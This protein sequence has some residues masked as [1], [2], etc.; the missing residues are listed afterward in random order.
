MNNKLNKHD[1]ISLALH[2]AVKR[3]LLSD[4][5]RVL[6]IAKNNLDRWR[7]NYNEIPQWMNDWNEILKQ[8]ASAVIKVLDG[9]DEVSTLL[10]SSSPFSGVISQEERTIILNKFKG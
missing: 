10:R 5:N 7:D 6:L 2:V 8:G 4:P 9:E 1:Q 3:E